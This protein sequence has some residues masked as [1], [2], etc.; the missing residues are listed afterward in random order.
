MMNSPP[1]AMNVDDRLTE[2]KAWQKGK[3]LQHTRSSFPPVRELCAFPRF[4]TLFF[5]SSSMSTLVL[6]AVCCCNGWG[7]LYR[8]LEKSIC[9]GVG[10]GSCALG[11]GISCRM[12]GKRAH[13]FAI[14]IFFYFVVVVASSSRR[15]LSLQRG[16]GF[17]SLIAIVDFDDDSLP[18]FPRA[19]YRHHRS[20]V[21]HF[22]SF[23]APVQALS[24]SS[25]SSA[26]Y[27][28][29]CNFRFTA[30]S[31]L[32]SEIEKLETC[33]SHFLFFKFHFT[34]VVSALFMMIS[35]VRFCFDVC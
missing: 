3:I 27:L 30:L 18:F 14:R 28:R 22:L 12:N 29:F 24:L 8:K 7:H 4:P 17:P 16:A 19:R 23:S 15:R 25:A 5:S 34:R 1:Y 26:M 33:H 6:S 9:R 20:A 2:K 31:E 13:G 35:A 10:R 32:S 21:S 11:A